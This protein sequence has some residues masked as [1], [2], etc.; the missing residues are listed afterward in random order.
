MRKCR[1]IETNLCYHLMNRMAHRAFFLT[2]D[3]RSRAIDLMRRAETFSGVFVLA[4]AFLTNHFHVYAYI[5]TP[6]ILND[7]EILHRIKTLYRGTSLTIILDEW[8]RLQDAETRLTRT[9]Q[10]SEGY[11]SQFAAFKKRLLMRMWKSSEFM[12]TFKQHFTMSYNGRHDHSGTMWE[13]RYVE[14]HHKPENPAMW[15]TAAYIDA[16]AVKAGLAPSAENYEWCSFA[17]ACHGDPKARRGYEF[18]YG[19]SGGWNIIRQKH[20]TSIAESLKEMLCRESPE[21]ATESRQTAEFKSRKDPSLECPS[22]LPIELERG[23]SSVAIKV[24]SFLADGPRTS[25]AIRAAVGVKSGD[26]FNRFYLR[27][28]LERGLIVR[29]IPDMPQSPNQMYRLP[30]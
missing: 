11:V 24:L 4:Y 12:R 8:K 23:D 30:T 26:Y 27:P 2:P 7:E 29:T 22:R 16:N 15:Q 1:H 21:T 19:Q 25:A 18:I 20:K 14:R 10:P 13:C 6:D 17:A 9:S 28:L 3:E 5:P